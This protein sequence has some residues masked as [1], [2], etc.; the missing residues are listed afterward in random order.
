MQNLRRV[1]DTLGHDSAQ[2]LLKETATRLGN[3]LRDSDTISLLSATDSDAS[4]SKLSE[5]EFGLMLPSVKDNASITW[6]VKRIFDALQEPLYINE[7]NIT[8]TSNVGIGVY[9]ADGD[10]AGMLIKHASISRHYAEQQAG[11][12]NVEYFSEHINR[13][14][15]EQLHLES[16]MA[17]P[18]KTRTLRLCINRRLIYRRV[19]SPALNRCCAGIIHSGVC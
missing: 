9:P 7:H 10:D 16:E 13:I 18:L 8:I 5:G 6:I 12:N 14:S 1:N 11:V 19:R 15:R 4:I 17:V 2:Q 3:V